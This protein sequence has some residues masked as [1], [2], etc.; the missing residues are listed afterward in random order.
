M[1][2][3]RFEP[4]TGDTGGDAPA[5][6]FSP[7][8]RSDELMPLLRY[9]LAIVVTAAALGAQFLLFPEPGYAFLLFYPAVFVTSWIAGTGPG[10]LA[11]LLSLVAADYLFIHPV[12][13]FK[14]GT[15]TDHARAAIFAVM[16]ILMSAANGRALRMQARE[17]ALM[18]ASRRNEAQLQLIA[19]ALPVLISY[20]DRDLIYRFA[21]RTYTEWFGL[22]VSEIIGHPVV[23]VIGPESLAGV[24]SRLDG[25]LRGEEA[26]FDAT[27][28]YTRGGTRHIQATYQPHVGPEGRILGFTALVEDVTERKRAEI[29]LREANERLRSAVDASEL[30][31]TQVRSSEERFRAIFDRAG[32]GMAE[33]DAA[34]KRFIDVNPKYCELTG[35]TRDE[36]LAMTFAEL[37]HPDDRAADAAALARGDTSYEVEKRYIRKDG[38][39][40]WVHVSATL[41]TRAGASRSIAVIHDVTFRRRAEEALRAAVAARDEF[42]SIAS[43]ELK[44]P[45]TSVKL[46]TQFTKR[47]ITRGDP[48][49]LRP[50]RVKKFIDSTDRQ[51]E[52]LSRLVDDMLDISRIASGRLTIARERFDL[53]EAVHDVVE[54]LSPVLADS[55]CE[56]RV[57]AQP[58][59][60]GAWDR[61]RIEQVLVNLLTNAA[62]YGAGKP[63]H[64]AVG[65]ADGIATITVADEGRGIAKEDHA[66]IFGRFE[67]AIAA[68]DPSGLGL[69]LYIAREIVDRH[70]GRIEVE[71]D[72]GRGAKFTVIL[73]S[74]CEP[75]GGGDGAAKQA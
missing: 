44:T 17:R 8:S 30:A 71:S 50:D 31:L 42:L 32:V 9:L 34:T 39:V 73:P 70:G 36:L 21:N 6:L 28:P 48:D 1:S 54:R 75:D 69:G 55:G 27:L 18:L 66:R 47:L 45:L 59:A 22:P 49:A 13:T 16:A 25:V 33:A 5:G 57:Q 38:R 72:I 74:T 3:D 67:R 53:A 41:L 35:Y 19:D 29:A 63:I 4:G 51:V 20:I 43:H 14:I 15:G 26:R 7:R 56:V 65:R 60:A 62:R 11:T 12:G 64:V 10:L 2:E 58:G 46:Q 52:R 23:D 24:R 68:G 40:I 37:T 61:F